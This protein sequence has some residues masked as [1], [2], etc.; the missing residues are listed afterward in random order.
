MRH[1]GFHRHRQIVSVVKHL[2]RQLMG[3]NLVPLAFDGIHLGA[4]GWQQKHDQTLGRPGIPLD[5][6]LPQA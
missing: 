5:M 1:T 2:A 3:F 4:I 6:F